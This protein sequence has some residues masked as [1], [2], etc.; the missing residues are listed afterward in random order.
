MIVATFKRDTDKGSISLSVTGHANAAKEGED[1]IC[2]AAS[3]L[4]YT[5][6]QTLQFSFEEGDL[7]EKPVI[8]ISKGEAYVEAIPTDEGYAL[9]LHTF[10][11]AQVGFSLLEHNYPD[12]A[13][14]ISFGESERT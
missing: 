11:V 13:K 6:A 8:D 10:F 9:A 4:A 3:M 7:K 12:H 14:I 2:A 1:L 5:V